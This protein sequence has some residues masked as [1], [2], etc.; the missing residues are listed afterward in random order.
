MFQVEVKWNREFHF[1]PYGTP[2]SDLKLAKAKVEFMKDMSDGEAVKD[3]R[4]VNAEGEV[5]YPVYKK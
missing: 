4:V 5:V 3:A 1:V 2:Y